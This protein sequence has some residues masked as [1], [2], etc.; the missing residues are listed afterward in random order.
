MK[1]LMPLA[2]LLALIGCSTTSNDVTQ[3][4]KPL[5]SGAVSWQCDSGSRII[6]LPPQHETTELLY[7]GNTLNMVEHS[8]STGSTLKGEGLTWQVNSLYAELSGTYTDDGNAYT[9]RCTQVLTP[10]PCTN[11]KN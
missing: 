3:N 7:H 9:E 4:L 11:T 1:R 10:N 5:P 2:M 8:S 6:V